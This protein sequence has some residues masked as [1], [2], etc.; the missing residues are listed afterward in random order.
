VALGCGLLGWLLEDVLRRPSEPH[1]FSKV[2]QGA[3]VPF[4]PVYAVGGALVALSM[5]R[6][7]RLS[8]PAR[9]G[10]YAAGLSVLEL[11]AGSLD[12]SIP[13]QPSWSYGLSGARVDLAHATAWGGLG[14]LAEAGLKRF[15]QPSCPRMGVYEN[16]I[17]G[18]SV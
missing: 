4:L 7:A 6:L 13:G 11:A 14:L 2:F 5:G 8:M 16:I 3:P 18:R 9:F 10:V 12:R 15:G 17:G 1:R